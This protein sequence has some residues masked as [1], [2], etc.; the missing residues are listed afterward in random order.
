MAGCKDVSSSTPGSVAPSISCND[1]KGEYFQLG[2]LRN[3][4][5]VLYFWSSKCC[6]DSLKRM[7]PFHE[8]QKNRGVSLVAVEVGG[9]KDSVASFVKVAGLSFVNLTDEYGTISKSYRVV[10]YP[11]IFVVDKK[12]IVQKKVSGEIKPDQLVQII[13]PFL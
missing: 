1:V 12:G 11:T 7:Q 3:N 8:Q 9:S 2:Q 4:L 10:G 6:G 13:T 5:V